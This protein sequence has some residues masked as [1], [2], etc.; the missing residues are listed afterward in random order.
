MPTPLRPGSPSLWRTLPMALMTLSLCGGMLWGCEEA[1]K[2]AAYVDSISD[3]APCDTSAACLGGSCLTDSQGYPGG[4]CTTLDCETQGCFG[5]RAECFRTRIETQDVTA[6]YEACQFDGTCERANEGYQCLTLAD[7]PVCLPPGVAGTTVQG[8][9]GSSCSNTAQCNGDGAS[10]LQTFFGGYC[11]I[12]GCAQASDCPDSNPCVPLNPEG[13]SEAD[14][15]YACMDGCQS[16]ADCRFGY[17]CQDYQGSSICLES[18][19]ADST[20]RNPDGA[21]DGAACV[22][23]INC[24]GGTCIKQVEDANSNISY[25]EGYCTTRDCD[26][27]A[28]CN[29]DG[30]LCISRERSTSCRQS[31]AQ[32]SD[33]RTG[34]EC[35]DGSLGQRYCESITPLPETPQEGTTNDAI[36]VSCSSSKT[37]TFSVPQGAVGFFIAPYAKSNDR[38]LLR[39]LKKPDGSTIDLQNDYGFLTINQDIL[40]NLAPILFPASDASQFANAFGGGEYTLTVE[41]RASEICHYVVPQLSEGKRVAI[42]LTFVGVPG[43]TAASAKND[44]DIKQM[45]ELMR[46]IYGKMGITVEVKNYIDAS[47]QVSQSYGIIRDFYD[48][49]NL[50][51]TSTSPGTSSSDALS[52]NVFLIEDFNVSDAPGLLGVSTGIPGMAGFHGSSGSGL[53][54]STASLGEDNVTLGQT[55]AHEVGHFLGLRHTTEHKG[56]D[57]DPITDTPRCAYPDL[58]FLCKDATNFMFPFSLGSGDQTVVSAGQGFVV[59]HNP[60]VQ[61]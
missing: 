36:E 57:E 21:D 30:S 40:G 39:T 37:I 45:V 3:G 60:L 34:Y 12:L 29:G 13:E 19:D 53:V 17:S 20:T 56:L 18:Q 9:V 43:V 51:A 59:R 22:A 6:C 47:A 31:C 24:K 55:L 48:V 11:A 8:V 58:A 23:N 14:K 52:V 15:Q 61:P 26:S 7:S 1:Q 27:D 2:I 50:V 54:F 16:D 33:C 44:R 25:P 46:T 42:N 49:F 38:V 4:Y 32:T 41:S 10:C 28:Q 5:L 35:I